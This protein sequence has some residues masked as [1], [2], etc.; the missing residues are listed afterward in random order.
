VGELAL[1]FPNDFPESA[2]RMF[3]FWFPGHVG[4]KVS[5]IFGKRNKRI[6]DASEGHMMS[7][8]MTEKSLLTKKELADRL[9]ITER[10]VQ[11]L[12]KTRRIPV[13]RLTGKTH[14]F[15]W[16]KVEEALANYEVKAVGNG[17]K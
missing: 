15:S 1:R 9:N 4:H 6:A 10:V 13:V 12:V 16:P 8:M 17:K 3:R 2:N 14:R 5:T 11:F 7:N